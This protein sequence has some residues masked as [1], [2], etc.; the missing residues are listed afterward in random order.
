MSLGVP[1]KSPLIVGAVEGCMICNS[2]GIQ[3]PGE[4]RCLNP[5]TSPEVQLLGVQNTDSHKVFG[6][7]WM[8]VGRPL[9]LG[10]GM[11]YF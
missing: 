3:T 4:D 11:T 7:F 8:M 5:Q 2:P 10:W 1:G 9:L 6:G